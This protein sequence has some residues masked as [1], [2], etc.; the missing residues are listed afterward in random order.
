MHGG[1]ERFRQALVRALAPVLEI[2]LLLGPG[3]RSG[4]LSRITSSGSPFRH[5]RTTT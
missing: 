4:P 5:G 2:W 3:G 1:P